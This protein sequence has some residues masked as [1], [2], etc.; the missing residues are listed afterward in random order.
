MRLNKDIRHYQ[1]L[2]I[3]G[4]S[5]IWQIAYHSFDR[6]AKKTI[7]K[8]VGGKMMGRWN[9]LQMEDNERRKLL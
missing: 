9:S 1:Y 7:L 8:A 3:K 4:L 5:Y 6:S 2:T